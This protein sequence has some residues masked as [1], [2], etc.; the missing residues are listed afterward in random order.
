MFQTN[1][2]FA[3]INRDKDAK[4]AKLATINNLK[5]LAIQKDYAQI[6]RLL[7]KITDHDIHDII[8]RIAII[9]SDEK[10]LKMTDHHTRIMLEEFAND[11]HFAW[12]LKFYKASDYFK[13]CDVPS[14]VWEKCTLKSAKLVHLY[15]EQLPDDFILKKKGYKWK[16][17]FN[18]C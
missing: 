7:E 13:N 11:D 3:L 10:L 4:L 2:A 5:T 12:L 8:A 6:K 14:Y 15:S 1:Y 18:L 17:Y 9:D 16:K